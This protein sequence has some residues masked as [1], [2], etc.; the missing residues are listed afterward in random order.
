MDL[1]LELENGKIK[2]PGTMVMVNKHYSHLLSGILKYPKCRGPMYTNKHA[3]TNKDGTYNEITIMCA[4]KLG[5]QEEKAV[6][7][8]QCLKKT[9][10]ELLVI[11]AIRE[12][13]KN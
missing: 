9:D 13:I 11:E 8:R 1:R 5:Q 2:H 6:T 3:W 12:L 7:I 4:A 10:I